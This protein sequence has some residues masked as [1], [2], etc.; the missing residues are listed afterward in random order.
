MLMLCCGFCYWV[1][2]EKV[3][4]EKAARLA[5][6][7]IE[8]KQQTRADVRLKY[9]VTNRRDQQGRMQLMATPQDTVYYY[10][11][12]VNEDTAGGFVIVAGDDA[13]R[14]VLGYSTYGIYNEN[15]LPPNFTCW[16]DNL[17]QEIAYAQTQNL[18][19]SEDIRQEWEHYISGTSGIVRHAKNIVGPLLQTKWNQYAPYNN[20]CPTNDDKRC[21]TGCV[22]T[23]MAQIMNYHRHPVRGRGQSTAYTTQTLKIDIPSVSFEVDYDWANMLNSY[24]GNATALQ[25]NAVATL[26]YHC[27]VSL[28][29]DYADE[30]GAS[31]GNVPIALTTF[32][33]YDKS[34]MLTSRSNFDNN[35][36]EDLLREQIDFGLPVYYAGSN[37]CTGH[38]FVCDGYDNTG[39]FHFN[40]GWG[41]LYDGYFVTTS[42]N[43]GMDFNRGQE[44]I[45]NIKPDG[46]PNLFNSGSGTNNAPYIIATPLQLASLA[47]LVNECNADYLDKHYKL[48]ADLDLSRYNASWMNG[49]GWTPI[50]NLNCPFKGEF[51]GNNKK[52]TGLYINTTNDYAGL[53]GCISESAKIQN[54]GIEKANI[55]GGEYVGGIVGSIDN[56]SVINC[57][58][59]GV[60]NGNIQ[61]GGIAG[62]VAQ[63]SSAVNCYSICMVS[64][65]EYVGGVI[66][67][68]ITGSNVSNCAALNPSIKG[69]SHVGRLAGENNG[70]FSGNIVFCGV[71]T[72]GGAAFRNEYV[73]GGS[74]GESKSGA[75]LQMA[76]GFPS[77][78]SNLPW[79]YIEG[80]LPGLLGQTVEM[81]EHLRTSFG[82]SGP[83]DIALD[84]DGSITVYPFAFVNDD[85]D[86]C[87]K[88][89]VFVDNEIDRTSLTFTCNNTGSHTVS[90]VVIDADGKRSQP[91]EVTFTISDK[92]PPDFDVIPLTVTLNEIGSI[93][94]YP[95]DFVRNI[96]DNC[97]DDQNITFLFVL[98]EV[99]YPSFTFTCND[100]GSRIVSIVAIDGNANRSLPQEISCTVIDRI[101]PK[102]DVI[103]RDIALGNNGSVT[104]YPTDF[105][106]NICDYD[107]N[108]DDIIFRFVVNESDYES[109]TYTCYDIDLQTVAIVAIVGICTRS[110]PKPVTFSIS[111][112]TPPFARCKP[113]TLH[114]DDDGKA[115]LTT[116]MIDNASEDNCGIE[117]MQ[118]KR[119]SDSDEQYADSLDFDREDLEAS[120]G[121]FISVTLLVRDF[122]ENETTCTTNIRL[123]GQ[124]KLPDLSDIPGIFTPNG[125]GF[126]DTWEIPGIDQIPE[127]NIRIYNRAKKLMVEIKGA[128]MPWD[129]RDRNGNLLESG[130]YFYQIELRREGK[131]ISGYITILR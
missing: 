7:Y 50:G 120:I 28:F 11:F 128:R 21:V 68:V 57:Y 53:F 41:G 113:V 85:P 62:A 49:A 51:D 67:A 44:I 69:N 55:K 110:Q 25:Q 36:W 64:G 15:N 106:E 70:I 4:A 30:S 111:D 114:L 124:T 10:V 91:E 131:V 23:A 12:N 92:T 20:L 26:M 127:A 22:A 43:P 60:V 122:S 63:N 71:S 2:A 13:V 29:M 103:P 93:T 47:N 33:G 54:L 94:V 72:D 83:R 118:I 78:F 102:F 115:T 87:D 84:N 90:I 109:L 117:L 96:S 121:S 108:I 18:P 77:E 119:S 34:I 45:I 40:W 76:T 1:Q 86:I 107:G 24:S 100:V 56:S 8:S 16:M 35:Y 105:V 17:K 98:N 9:T 101:P 129:G 6:R 88:T 58:S 31:S 104:I 73:A 81:P 116:M 126:N 75:D 27:G 19:Q 130:Y 32:F 61:V 89:F 38:A 79:T 59:T 48:M 14:P 82:L 99:D 37:S 123:A 3:D 65:S 80:M 66:G 97:S 42:L 74:G 5:Q 46:M 95:V 112:Q 125:D 52:I 39:L